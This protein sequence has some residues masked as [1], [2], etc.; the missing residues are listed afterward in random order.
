MNARLL[1]QAELAQRFLDDN[2]KQ[3]YSS[4]GLPLVIAGDP[5][6]SRFYI[7]AQEF[8]GR[9]PDTA[10]FLVRL[11]LTRGALDV[12]EFEET[13]TLQRDANDKPFLIDKATGGPTRALGRGA[14][15]VS[16][17]IASG[18][19]KVTFDSD[20]VPDSVADGV[21]VL[22]G[23]GKRLGGSST[24]AANRTVVITGLQ[25]V[26][27]VSYRLVILPSVRDVGGRNIPS[28][29]DLNLVGPATAISTGSGDSG[30]QLSPEPSDPALPSPSPRRSPVPS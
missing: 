10:R 3:A 9:L 21:I 23:T 27:G 13:L 6:F 29:Y 30:N 17:D 4:S 18:S 1:R 11:V 8:T 20:L 24:Y 16:I 7:V 19:I 15:V 14:E 12:S 2:G 22:D 28:R 5:S 25:L 26:P